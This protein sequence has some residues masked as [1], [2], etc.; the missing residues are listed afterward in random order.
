M[1]DDSVSLKAYCHP[2]LLI[3]YAV[4]LYFLFRDQ[5]ITLI[6][7]GHV[8]RNLWTSL[9]GF[10]LL[11]IVCYALI[12]LW[13]ARLDGWLRG[14]PIARGVA[15]CKRGC[16]RPAASPRETYYRPA[17]S[18]AATYENGLLGPR[19]PNSRNGSR[20]TALKIEAS[21]LCF[22]MRLVR[23]LHTPKSSQ[24]TRA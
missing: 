24:Q 12:S 19:K 5:I 18:L 2:K 13:E 6:P 7:Q 14:R 17:I 10:A 22:L 23:A 20:M 16:S 11:V 4:Y 9:A 21:C 1:N 15:Q 8:N 3:N